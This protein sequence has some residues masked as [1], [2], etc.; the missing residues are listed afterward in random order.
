MAIQICRRCQ[1]LFY[2]LDRYAQSHNIPIQTAAY[3]APMEALRLAPIFLDPGEQ[4]G[5]GNIVVFQ[6]RR[7]STLAV[8]NTDGEAETL[9]ED[10]LGNTDGTIRHDIEVI[11][12][13]E[14]E[15]KDGDTQ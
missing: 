9:T 14:V 2:E 1:P 5:A 10:V 3:S 13:K 4:Q 8:I 15:S 12:K 7:F 6:Y 11:R